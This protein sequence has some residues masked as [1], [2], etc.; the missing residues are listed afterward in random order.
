MLL[1]RIFAFFICAPRRFA[2]A[3][4]TATSLHPDKFERRKSHFMNLVLNLPS[5]VSQDRSKP[6]KSMPRIWELEKSA[7]RRPFRACCKCFST[8][9]LEVNLRIILGKSFI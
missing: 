2:E 6:D 8:A 9:F 4:S 5:K 7:I 3:K 1:L